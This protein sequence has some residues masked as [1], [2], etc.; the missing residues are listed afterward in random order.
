MRTLRQPG[1]ALLPRMIA[2]EARCAGRMRVVL[3]AG[4]EL[5]AGAIA[6]LA[7]RPAAIALIGGGFAA[8]QYMTG[9]PDHSG[10]RVATYGE[11]TPL[12]GAITLVSGNAML[13]RG[14]DGAPAM[15]CHAVVVAADGSVHGG[16]L[17][18]GACP[19]GRQGLTLVATLLDGAAFAV[20]EDSE[21]N[22]ALLQPSVTA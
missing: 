7:G 11:P 6:A 8:L 21:T 13:G 20:A 22:Y 5:F 12:A 9:Q 4:A 14:A 15:H 10:R 18:P 2:A 1:P 3:P 19:A 17:V 16:H